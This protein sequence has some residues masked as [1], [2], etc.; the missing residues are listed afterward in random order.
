M[1]NTY[2]QKNKYLIFQRTEENRYEVINVLDDET[3]LMD[4][5]DAK[6]LY[7]LNGKTDPYL[8]EGELTLEERDYL[9]QIFD[10]CDLL[11]EF[12][13]IKTLGLGEA[14]LSI[15]V[16]RHTRKG[17]RLA[18]RINQALLF[19]WLPVFLAGCRD[20][21]FRDI[22][23]GGDWQYP[24][25]LTL[26]LLSALCLHECGHMCA[27]MA[28]GGHV[29]EYGLLISHFLPGA[30]VT[31][32]ENRIKNRWKRI[33]VAA[34]GIEVNLL[35]AGLFALL[36]RFLPPL[37]YMFFVCSFLNFIMAITNATLISGLDGL[38]VFSLLL[39]TEDLWDMAKTVIF[40]GRG[41]RRTG[42]RAGRRA[43]KRREADGLLTA[44]SYICCLF[45]TALPL[46]LAIPLLEI[47]G[48]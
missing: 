10:E 23:T 31:M 25:G 47:L 39:G 40:S 5:R 9:L 35:L 13:R 8:I 43:R 4:E 20:L 26:G 14:M 27:V 45:Q 28:Y 7:R 48:V 3:W 1:G 44:A 16:P 42:K 2:P 12:G 24:A 32:D 34:A 37:S 33:Q 41:K 19:L 46:L 18:R 11:E 38:K 29:F 36:E 15:G 6:F 30:F 21:F 22:L 17:R